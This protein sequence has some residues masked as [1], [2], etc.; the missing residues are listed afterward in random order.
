MSHNLIY[1]FILVI[2]QP[3]LGHRLNACELWTNGWKRRENTPRQSDFGLFVRSGSF[4]VSHLHLQHLN[5]HQ[6]HKEENWRVMFQLNLVF[7]WEEV[8]RQRVW[9]K[10]QCVSYNE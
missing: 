10:R 6:C 8:G 5:R 9:K 2:S 7:S 3:I 1:E 4:P